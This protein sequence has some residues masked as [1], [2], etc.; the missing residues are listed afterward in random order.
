M[1]LV[2]VYHHIGARERYFGQL[3]ESLKPNGR[4]AIIDFRMD[5]TMGPSQAMRITPEQVRME[6][7]KAGYVQA[8]EHGF[9]PQQYFLV[10][11][12]STQ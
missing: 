11:R 5:A 3:R 6:L 7:A 8:E 10:F 2:D 12:R 4:L 1:I 9:L